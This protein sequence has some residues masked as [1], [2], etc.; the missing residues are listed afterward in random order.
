MNTTLE[1]A[2]YL[3]LLGIT[4]NGKEYLNKY[5]SQFNLPLISKLSAYKGNDILLDIKASRVYSFG[6]ENQTKDNLLH[7]EY[8]QP[9]IYIE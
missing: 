2:A 9:P 1:N 6:I 5:K 8:K 3:R 7:Q 4:K